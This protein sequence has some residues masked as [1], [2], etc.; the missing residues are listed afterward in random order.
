M[1]LQVFVLGGS[2]SGP[3]DLNKDAELY[4]PTLGTWTLLPGIQAAYILT[5]DPQDAD[6]GFNYRGDNYGW[7]FSWSNASG[8]AFQLRERFRPHEHSRVSG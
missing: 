2:W 7:F 8:I 5:K 1:A 4:N 3:K 6:K